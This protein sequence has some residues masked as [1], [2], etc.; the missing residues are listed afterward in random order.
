LSAPRA[1]PPLPP[2]LPWVGGLYMLVLYTAGS[3]LCIITGAVNGAVANQAGAPPPATRGQISNGVAVHQPRPA[4]RSSGVP[5]QL[6]TYRT[7]SCMASLFRCW[8]PCACT[9]DRSNRTRRSIKSVLEQQQ[10][11]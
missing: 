1:P 7:P 4:S 5:R 3:G 11:Q 8:C 2:P 6:L 10:Q 9:L